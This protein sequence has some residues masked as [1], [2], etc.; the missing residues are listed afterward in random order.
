[1]EEKNAT[2]R[3]I[4]NV[5]LEITGKFRMVDPTGKILPNEDT[6]YLCRCGASKNKPFCDDSHVL[7]GFSG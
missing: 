6:V 7:T 4:E 5:P 2:F 1:M 3:V